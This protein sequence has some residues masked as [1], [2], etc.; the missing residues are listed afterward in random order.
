MKPY[1]YW[2]NIAQIHIRVQTD[3]VNSILHHHT[4]M[5]PSRSLFSRAAT[6]V[7][8][9]SAARTPVGSFRGSLASLS[10]VQLG[11]VAAQGAIKQAG[12]VLRRVY[13]ASRRWIDGKLVL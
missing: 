2:K 4:I 10:A 8:I 6:D 12:R 9:C 3:R 1:A 13:I 11:A 7:V 5:I